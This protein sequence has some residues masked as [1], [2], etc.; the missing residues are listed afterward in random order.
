MG[1]YIEVC[2]NSSYYMNETGIEIGNELPSSH[3]FAVDSSLRHQPTNKNPLNAGVQASVDGDYGLGV[4]RT[5]VS[6]I[7]YDMVSAR[8]Y[9][10]ELTIDLKMLR[11]SNH[12]WQLLIPLSHVSHLT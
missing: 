11:S 7:E 2:C 10:T 5:A 9:L 3:N 1:N 6:S 8:R 4:A 12:Y